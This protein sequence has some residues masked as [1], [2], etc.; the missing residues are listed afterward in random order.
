MEKPKCERCGEQA[1]THNWEAS[2]TF[3]GWFGLG[4]RTIVQRR[5]RL[6]S[7]YFRREGGG[8]PLLLVD[9][10]KPLCM[11]CWGDLVVFLQGRAVAACGIER[12][13]RGGA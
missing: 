1:E 13:E 4:T 5:V 9:E 6:K 11:D 3:W 7:Q 8:S 12:T 10:T 2:S